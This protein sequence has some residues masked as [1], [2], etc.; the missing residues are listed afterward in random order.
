MRPIAALILAIPLLC[1]RARGQ[2]NP[3][4]DPKRELWSTVKREL[5]SPEGENYFESSLKDALLPRLEGTL[6]AVSRR[7]GSIRLTLARTD[8][9][10]PEVTLILNSLGSKMKDEPKRGAQVLFEA[11]PIAFAKEPFLVTF[12]L[13]DKPIV[14]EP[15][16][17]M[18][19]SWYFGP[20]LDSVHSARYHG[21]PT[22]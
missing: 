21:N 22:A 15:L 7:E 20:A 18:A 6:L 16:G 5:R 2:T 3:R 13:A 11:V 10:T 17:S 4:V 8:A 9:A 12:D 1:G 14:I 19:P